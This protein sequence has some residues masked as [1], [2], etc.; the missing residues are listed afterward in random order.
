MENTLDKTDYFDEWLDSLK[1]IVG[2]QAIN[3]RIERA[4]GGN[5]GD[6]KWNIR[7]GVSEMRIDVGPGYRLYFCQRGKNLYLLLVGGTKN[8][9]QRAIDQAI[10][11]KMDLERENRW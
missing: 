5:F 9:Q 11:F 10:D 8:Q 7:E 4:E 2:K 6:C 3:V 1:D